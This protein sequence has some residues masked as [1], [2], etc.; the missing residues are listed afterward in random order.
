MK[1]SRP[2]ISVILPFYNAE[3]YIYDSVKCIINQTF[4]NLELILINDGSNDSSGDIAQSISDRRIRYFENKNNQG[5]IKTLNKGLHF[6]EGKFIARMDADDLCYINRF[7]KQIEYFKYNPDIDILGTGQYI[8]GT[9]RTYIHKLSNEENR[10]QLFLQPIVGHSSVMLKKEALYKNN[11]YYDK[12]ALYAED[13]K[14]WIDASLCGL[15]ICN[16]SECLCGY[17]IHEKQISN[18]QSDIQRYIADKIRIAY[19]KHFFFN[20]I[21]GNELV[22]LF[23]IHGINSSFKDM[24]IAQIEELYFKLLTENEH[25]GFFDN[26]LFEKYLKQQMLNVR[27]S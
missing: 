16:L 12:N 17:R 13:Y 23:F 5:L 18:T 27:N 21:E 8:I 14:L 4:D 7:E 19:A 25:S 15:T 10:I 26:D 22:Y 9:D 1:Q 24:Y 3:Q 11:L 20:V 6:A 2:E